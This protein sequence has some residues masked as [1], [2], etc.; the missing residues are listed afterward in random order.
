MRLLATTHLQSLQLQAI[1]MHL[2]SFLA[3]PVGSLLA[4]QLRAANVCVNSGVPCAC[5]T[6]RARECLH[7]LVVLVTPELK[8]IA[9]LLMLSP[10]C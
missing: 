1:I 9:Q 10:V 7:A 6:Q 8:C 3:R 5:S 2:A 4:L